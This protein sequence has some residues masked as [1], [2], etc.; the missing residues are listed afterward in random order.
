MPSTKTRQQH[1]L[2]FTVLGAGLLLLVLAGLSL[3]LGAGPV[4]ISQSLRAIMTPTQALS[5]AQF[6]VFELRLPRLGLALVVG[7]AL[8]VAG[9]VLQTV[10]RNTLA[11]PG[12]LG[13]S[14]GAAFAV[15]MAIYWGASAAT[16]NVWVAIAGALVGC[17]LVL[18]AT[19][20]QGVKGDPVR[21]ILAGAAFSSLLMAITSVILLQ[22]QRTADEM[23]FWLIGALAGRPTE[24]IWV[25][26]SLILAGLCLVALNLRALSAL[27]LGERIAQGLGHKPLVLQLLALLAVAILVG[28]A[29]AAAGPIAFIGLVVP[30]IA[31]A[32]V[33]PD[34][35]RVF[36]TSLVLGP[37]VLLAADILS[38]LLV[39]PYE[40][41]VGVIS[42]FVGAP[43]LILVV[44]Q[45]R[46]PTL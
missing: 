37:V 33:G 39:P 27:A 38:R 28:A 11:E 21:L 34:I 44:R 30:F 16:V 31:R 1:Q 46:L 6:V 19:Q 25:S 9:A 12:L 20:I 32:C 41:P 18:A 15:V 24:A 2:R 23:R 8:A 26:G 36:V 7:S 40:L 22:D 29:T 14:A 45:R 10:T 3:L 43:I 35:R 4:S 17:L 13:V 42:A 5:E